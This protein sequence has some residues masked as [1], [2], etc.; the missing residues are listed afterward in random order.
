MPGHAQPCPLMVSAHTSSS[1]PKVH[2]SLACP[3]PAWP[4][5][6]ISCC[7]G[8][9]PP[10]DTRWQ[11][12]V[13]LG[14]TWCAALCCRCPCSAAAPFQCLPAC[15]LAIKHSSCWLSASP[16]HVAVPL[17]LGC[18]HLVPECHACCAVHGSFQEARPQ[19]AWL[20]QQAAHALTQRCSLCAL[21]PPCRS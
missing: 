3:C 7:R 10:E 6:P 21:R 16:E 18:L 15:W 19:A 12:Y 20:G 4:H 13:T 8:V 5:S 9:D 11:S 2:H 14:C 1:P 17:G